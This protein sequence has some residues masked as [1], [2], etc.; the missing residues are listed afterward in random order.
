MGQCF[1]NFWTLNIYRMT[2]TKIVQ[3][4]AMWYYHQMPNFVNLIIPSVEFVYIKG[5]FFAEV[6][7]SGLVV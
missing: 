6:N 7:L 1:I 5:F 4:T 2:Q 3:T